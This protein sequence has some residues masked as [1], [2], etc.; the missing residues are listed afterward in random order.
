MLD[1]DTVRGIERRLRELN[2]NPPFATAWYGRNKAYAM[3][4]VK[5]WGQQNKDKVRAYKKI[6]D[7]RNRARR[8]GAVGSFTRVQWEIIKA[9]YNNKCVY[10]GRKTKKLTPDHIIPISRG[11]MNYIFNIVPCCGY[12]NTSKNDRSLQDWKRFK[13]LQLTLGIDV[14]SLTKST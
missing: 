3:A 14:L 6:V 2:P 5:R 11:G 10:C 13:G 1:V 8:K 12:C 4:R 7:A 9:D